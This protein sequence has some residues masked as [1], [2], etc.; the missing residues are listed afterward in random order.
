MINSGVRDLAAGKYVFRLST[1]PPCE[2]AQVGSFICARGESKG[3]IGRGDRELF[4]WLFDN[5]VKE[6]FSVFLADDVRRI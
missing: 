3:L 2:L 1:S 4:S 5:W 6:G